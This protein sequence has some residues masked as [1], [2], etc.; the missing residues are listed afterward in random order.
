MIYLLFISSSILMSVLLCFVLGNTGA[1]EDSGLRKYDIQSRLNGQR[2]TYILVI[3]YLA[4]EDAGDYLCTLKI[5]G[6]EWPEWPTKIGKLTVQ[7][8]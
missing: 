5:Q 7:S 6:V 2:I 4:E 8:K 1:N 3:R